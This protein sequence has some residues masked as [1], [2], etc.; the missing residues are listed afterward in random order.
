MGE[1]ASNGDPVLSQP[2]ADEVVEAQLQESRRTRADIEMKRLRADTVANDMA[3][4]LRRIAAAVEK[5]PQTW[6]DLFGE[7]RS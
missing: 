2:S 6:D 3:R 7:D 5:N 4:V 1:R